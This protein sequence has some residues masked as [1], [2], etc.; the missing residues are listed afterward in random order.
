MRYIL[1]KK[2][3]KP[4]HIIRQMCAYCGK[5][6]DVVIKKFED[7]ARWKTLKLNCQDVFNYLSA[8]ERE[9]LISGLCPKCQEFFFEGDD[10]E[11]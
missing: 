8:T 9:Q 3:G 1:Q 7:Y 11:A 5:D 6:H 10:N 4:K 2:D